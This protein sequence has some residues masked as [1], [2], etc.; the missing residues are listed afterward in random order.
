VIGSGFAEYITKQSAQ[1]SRTRSVRRNVFNVKGGDIVD[2]PK[3]APRPP[4]NVYER[5]ASRIGAKQ[6][7]QGRQL[8]LPL[9]PK[10]LNLL[11]KLRK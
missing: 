5:F 6:G 7:K 4:V 2:R 1:R 11:K 9:D 10:I 3:P 8:M